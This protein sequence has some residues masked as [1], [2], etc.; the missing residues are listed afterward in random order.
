MANKFINP[1]PP[2]VGVV[3]GQT[4]TL[5]IPI[6]PR[7]HVLWFEIKG[8]KATT[9]TLDEV[10]GDIRVKLNGKPARIH[11]AVQL[12]ALNKLMGPEFAAQSVAEAVGADTRVT[13]WLPVFLAEPWRKQYAETEAMAWPTS[14]PNG[15]K[16]QTFQV[17][18]DIANTSGVTEQSV[19]AF[20]E[21]DNVLGQVDKDGKPLFF[22]SK[23]NRVAAPYTAAGDLYITTLPKREIYQQISLFTTTDKITQAKVKVD[24]VIVRDATKAQNDA[25]LVARGMNSAGLSNYRFD[26]VFDYDDNPRS[27]LLMQFG[28]V[29]VQDF[30]VIPTLDGAAATTKVVTVLYQTYG[31]PD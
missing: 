7:Y 19:K 10:V 31:R 28:S 2:V 24:G 13:W 14:W 25:T 18:L 12:D 9:P 26:L 21:T 6:G 3:P 22:V 11:T 16:V 1:L 8:R 30:Q 20:A 5:D 17:E 15:E 29:G 27:A 4:A 23:W